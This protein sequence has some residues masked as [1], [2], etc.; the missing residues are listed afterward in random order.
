ML[1]PLLG[2][3]R[4]T[5]GLILA[6]A[7][8]ESGRADLPT[9]WESSDAWRTRADHAL[10]ALAVIIPFALGDRIAVLANVLRRLGDL[11]SRTRR[12]RSAIRSS[13]LS[14]RVHC[15]D[16]VPLL[17]ALLGR[18]SGERRESVGLAYA[19]N[20]LVRLP[21]RSPAD[22]D[23]C[24]CC[25]RRERGARDGDPRR[26]AGR[27]H[28]RRG[29]KRASTLAS[30][31]PGCC[32]D[33]VRDRGRRVL[34]HSESRGTSRAAGLDQG[35]H[36]HNQDSERLLWDRTVGNECGTAIG[37]DDISMIVNGKI[38]RNGDG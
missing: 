36:R 33:V 2:G 35:Q 34:R 24:H 13:C 1:G 3:R 4:F 14:G 25:Q 15:G 19:W 29:L 28:D 21:D 16:S 20:T 23:C 27:A 32:F 22:S 37:G 26:H 11:G 8:G 17:I 9:G 18:G 7:M 10:E 30:P 31:S 12:R 38:R 6:M 5:L